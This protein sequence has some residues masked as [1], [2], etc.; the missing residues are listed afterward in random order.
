MP[1]TLE[2]V[3]VSEKTII[4][5]S[6]NGFECILPDKCNEKV[7]TF[8]HGNDARLKQTYGKSWRCWSEMPCESDLASAGKLVMQ[9]IAEDVFEELE[10]IKCAA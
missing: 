6:S 8:N 4:L 1:L 3:L 2:Q 9:Y 10:K 7:V 5:E